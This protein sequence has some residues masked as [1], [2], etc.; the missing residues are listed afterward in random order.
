MRVKAIVARCARV[1]EPHERTVILV[2]FENTR[3]H[4]RIAVIA[5]HRDDFCTHAHRAIVPRRCAQMVLA[6]GVDA[7][8]LRLLHIKLRA[9]RGG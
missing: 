2:R 5:K 4:F 7:D 8:M 1:H 6:D 3:P 9:R